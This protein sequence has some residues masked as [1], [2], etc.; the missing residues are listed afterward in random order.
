MCE[1]SRTEKHRQIFFLYLYQ[2]LVPRKKFNKASSREDQF[3]VLRFGKLFFLHSL[4]SSLLGLLRLPKKVPLRRPKAAT[5]TV[6]TALITSSEIDL[7]NKHHTKENPNQ[8][9]VGW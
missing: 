1:T 7:C 9:K 4:R 5:A 6:T 3:C 8:T 2:S